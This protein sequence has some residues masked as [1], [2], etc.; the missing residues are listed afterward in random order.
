MRP[1]FRFFVSAA[2][3]LALGS[4]LARGQS[5]QVTNLISDSTALIPAK[6]QDP[7]L[8]NPWGISFGTGAQGTPFW[9]SDNNGGVSTVYSL[10]STG[11]QL[12]LLVPVPLPGAANVGTSTGTPTGTVF[13]PASGSFQYT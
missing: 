7:N 2:L 3:T 10:T 8:V 12:Q 6:L 5:Y 11:P 13:N 9:F 4:A 1:D